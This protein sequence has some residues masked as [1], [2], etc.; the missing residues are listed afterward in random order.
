SPFSSSRSLCFLL[1]R[2]A[3]RHSAYHSQRR[4]SKFLGRRLLSPARITWCPLSVYGFHRSPTGIDVRQGRVAKMRED[5]VRKRTT[6]EALGRGPVCSDAGGISIG[7]DPRG[8]SPLRGSTLL[9]CC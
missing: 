2:P 8:I 3:S 5:V 9:P 7:K 4:P 1:L 6:R